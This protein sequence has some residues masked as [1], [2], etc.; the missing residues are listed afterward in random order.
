MSKSKMKTATHSRGP[1]EAECKDIY[2]IDGDFVARLY[3]TKPD[4]VEA[5]AHLIAAAPE[6]LAACKEAVLYLEAGIS[7]TRFAY[8][9]RCN[10]VQLCR[11]AIAKAEGAGT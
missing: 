6:L 2:D 8:Q 9:A 4:E 1:W 3:N 11:A 5:N 7:S 10:A